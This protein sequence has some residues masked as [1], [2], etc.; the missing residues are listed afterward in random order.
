MKSKIALLLMSLFSASSV[1]AADCGTITVDC[2]S[3][4][5]SIPGL[6]KYS[7]SC[8]EADRIN[9]GKPTVNSPEGHP[10]RIGGKHA[11]RIVPNGQRIEG[12]PGMGDSGGG[13]VFHTANPRN[14]NSCPKA[15]NWGQGCITVTNAALQRLRQCVG[16]SLIIKNASAARISRAEAKA[17]VRELMRDAPKSTKL[18]NPLTS[19]TQDNS[20]AR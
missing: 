2:K 18:R 10:G 16:S 13:K 17:N 20:A 3:G 1:L 7:G 5:I 15:A 19:T 6:Q 9:C 4:R 14:L 12:I 11:G 8:G